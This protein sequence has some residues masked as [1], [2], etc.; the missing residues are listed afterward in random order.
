[1]RNNGNRFVSDYIA[2]AAGGAMLE[3]AGVDYQR[4][5]QVIVF[6]DGVYW[7][8]TLLGAITALFIW[9]RIEQKRK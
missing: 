3:G 7:G 8:G 2:D 5:R 1:L 9:M 4:S 6:Y